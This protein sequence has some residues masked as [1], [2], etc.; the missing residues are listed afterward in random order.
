MMRLSR[1]RKRHRRRTRFTRFEAAGW[2]AKYPATG[3]SWS[4]DWD[5]LAAVP[6][7]TGDPPAVRKAIFATNAI[8]SLNYSLRKVLK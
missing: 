2:G 6:L 8:E 1:L 7:S 3:P 5:R 4:A